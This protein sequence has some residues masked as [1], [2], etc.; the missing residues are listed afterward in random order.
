[1]VD[2]LL[3]TYYIL[4]VHVGSYPFVGT[5]QWVDHSITL[6][7]VE[8]NHWV[9]GLKVGVVSTRVYALLR[10]GCPSISVGLFFCHYL[11]NFFPLKSTFHLTFFVNVALQTCPRLP[12]L[13]HFLWLTLSL[14]SWTGMFQQDHYL[15]LTGWRLDS[16]PRWHQCT[17]K[18]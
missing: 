11:I 6:L 1:M 8:G 7:L 13:S 4:I 16:S 10:W 15:T 12:S 3:T 9:K 5:H 17:S 2:L 18:F 14:S